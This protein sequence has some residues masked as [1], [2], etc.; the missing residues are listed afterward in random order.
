LILKQGRLRSNT[1]LKERYMKERYMN[2]KRSMSSLVIAAVLAVAGAIVAGGQ[3]DDR[4]ISKKVMEGS[5][6]VTV[7]PMP[8]PAPLPPSFEAIITYVPGGGLTE[9]DNLGVPGQVAGAGQGAWELVEPRQFHITF[10]KYIFSAQGQFQGTGRVTER[11]IRDPE[12][13]HYTGEGKIEIFDPSGTLIST[14]PVTSA[15]SRIRADIE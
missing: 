6:R 10:T 11:I 15:A 13:G 14:I 7:T 4:R 9:S 1:Q 3:A 8:S 5:W 12:D 2:V